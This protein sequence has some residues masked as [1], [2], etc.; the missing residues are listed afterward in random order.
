MPPANFCDEGVRDPDLPGDQTITPTRTFID[1]EQCCD[2]FQ[3]VQPAAPQAVPRVCAAGPNNG[4]VAIAGADLTLNF[5]SF[6][7]C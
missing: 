3:L 7:T 2:R 6:G 1:A 5:L 4:I